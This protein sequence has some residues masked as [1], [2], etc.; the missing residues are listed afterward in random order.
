[1]RS[2]LPEP[3]NTVFV[4]LYCDLVITGRVG[5][6]ACLSPGARVRVCVGV[7]VG[8]RVGVCARHF[9]N[10]RRRGDAVD[11]AAGRR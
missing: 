11:L 1:V 9:K 6:L 3:A 8:V 10:R 4:L 7:C 2:Y 5:I